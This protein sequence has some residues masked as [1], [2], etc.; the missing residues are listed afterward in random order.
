MKCLCKLLSL[1]I[2]IAVVAS[3]LVM[4]VMVRDAM[5]QVATGNCPPVAP[6]P[7]SP[8][9]GGNYNT[10]PNAMPSTPCNGNGLPANTCTDASSTTL[11]FCW[12]GN[13]APEMS[14]YLALVLIVAGGAVMYLRNRRL[15]ARA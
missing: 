12:A 15:S 6:A 1:T 10:P 7:A 11:Y 14:D 8:N 2:M 13:A 9:G 4:P 5:A 3:L